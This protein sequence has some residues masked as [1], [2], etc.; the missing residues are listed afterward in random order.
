M[1]FFLLFAILVSVG[2]SNKKEELRLA[3]IAE[4]KRVA[5]S[6]HIADSIATHLEAISN[7][8]KHDEILAG[9]GVFQVI[10]RMGID[11]NTRMDLINKL[12]FNVELINLVAGE[13]F[14]AQFTP[15]TSTLLEFHYKPNRITNH[16]ITV[17]TAT[18]EMTYREEIKDTETRHRLVNGTLKAGSTLNQA[19]L[20]AGFSRSI[21]QV[22]NGILLCKI[23][24]RTDARVNDKF[25]VLMQEEFYNDSIVSEK[26]KV[27]YTSYDG[28]RTNFHEAYRYS[29]RDPKSIYNAHYTPDGQALVHSG[30][31]YPVDRLHVSSNYGMRIHPVTGRRKLHSGVDYSGPVG[32]PIYSV[33]SGRVVVSSYDK[34]SGNKVAVRH[35]DRS[36][37]YY[38]HLSRKLVSVGQNVRSRQM[39]GK[40]GKTG[41]VTGSHLHLGFKKPN[42]KWMNPNRKRMIATPKLKG[43]R[44]DR[45]E[46][47]IINIKRVR[48][49]LG[50]ADV[51]LVEGVVESSVDSSGLTTL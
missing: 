35:A 5:D 36:T 8:W 22:V 50:D 25:S 13:K 44:F 14:S 4:V 38:L 12:R 24:F 15:D 39:I 17:D 47:Q 40:M 19:L 27:L 41:R 23:S 33:A 31:R 49:A 34:Y 42:G 11:N 43:D 3:N 21:T 29:D 51:R 6:V 46:N 2:C 1:R 30:I 10:E 45:L 18:N 16:I 37:S 28:V 20:D 9:N 26:T 7:K 48:L 32:T